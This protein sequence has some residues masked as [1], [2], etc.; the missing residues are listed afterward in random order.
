MTEIQ[1]WAD[2][3]CCLALYDRTI[4]L[5]AQK[6]E[7]RVAHCGPTERVGIGL[8]FANSLAP[9]PPQEEDNTPPHHHH[10][11]NCPYNPAISALTFSRVSNN[12]P[13]LQRSN[14]LRSYNPP[15]TPQHQ[16]SRHRPVSGKK[17]QR[18]TVQGAR[19]ATSLSELSGRTN[20]YFLC[21]LNNPHEVQARNID[22]S[23]GHVGVETE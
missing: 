3:K 11:V 9:S 15:S 23:L 21:S 12:A 22:V 7:T 6:N 4:S 20:S 1:N 14:E 8:G 13:F 18:W 17:K 16:L 19:R 10:Q 5:T 2:L